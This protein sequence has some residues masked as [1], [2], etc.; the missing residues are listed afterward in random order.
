MYVLLLVCNL[1]C[2]YMFW[3]AGIR[4]GGGGAGIRGWGAGI[5][6]GRVGIRREGW[7]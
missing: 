1:T 5:R 6:G 2:R 4:E 3:G 7:V